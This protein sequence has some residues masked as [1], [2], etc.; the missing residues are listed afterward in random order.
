[1]KIKINNKCLSFNEPK[2]ILE[3]IDNEDKKY[4]AARVN[5]RLRELD[6]VISSDSEVE[7]L[8]FNDASAVRIYQSTLRYI[9][10]MAINNLYP[11][12]KVCFNYSV[13]RSIFASISNLGHAF[14][15]KNL[16]EISKELDKIIEDDYPIKRYSVSKEEA[17][18]YYES[19]G[20]YDKVKILKYR[21]ENTVHMYECNGYKNYMFGY[22]LPSTGYL[23][24]YELK[25]YNPGFLITYPRSECKGQIPEFHDERVFRSALKE[26]N[27]WANTSK[28]GSISQ[29][30]EIVEEGKALEFINICEAKHNRQLAELGRQ[31]SENIDNIRL[32]CV[33][34]P[35]SSG[36]TTFT[37]RLRI[38]LKSR[39][40]EPLMISMD[41]F[42]LNINDAPKDEFGN[43]DLEHIDALDLKLFDEIIFKLIQGEEVALP[44]YNFLDKKRTFSKPVRINSHQP[45]L[46]EG[47]HGLNDKIAPSISNDN[48]YKIY[49]APLTQYKIDD[50]NP[51]SISDIRLIRRMV[52]DHQFR[53]TGCEKTLASWQSVRN[54]EFKWI[55]PYQNNADFVFNSELS[56]ELCVM[57][58]HAI[59]LLS[60]VKTDSENY[61][62]ANR[63]LKFLKYFET[64][65]DKWIPCNSIL[66]EFIGDSIFYTEDV[67]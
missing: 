35:S 50:H 12:A 42:Y 20:W 66:R 40:I 19:I 31:I 9:V 17:I 2:R 37:N 28:S 64:I 46:I 59:P 21:K 39:G 23:K 61:I 18:K 10:V 51:I 56:Y 26:A 8:D 49:I 16:Q 45:I 7:L 58:K 55:Y 29:M 30:N 5:N 41:N 63:L 6:Y 53:G 65:S 54:G 36:K 43:P 44:I 25:L 27:I 24:T 13:S 32:I 22:M 57:K 33:A 60:E 62:T 4:L 38:E 14:L 48:K 47:I 34:G 1:M 15:D 52:R 67:K 3:M 11:K